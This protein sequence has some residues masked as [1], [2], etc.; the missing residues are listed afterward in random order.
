MKVKLRGV[1][2][3]IP[4]ALLVAVAACDPPHWRYLVTLAPPVALTSLRDGNAIALGDTTQSSPSPAAAVGKIGSASAVDL[5]SFDQ[6]TWSFAQRLEPRQ[7]A[8]GLFATSVALSG[9]TLAIGAYHDDP[10]KINNGYVDIY[11]RGN[12]NW[13]YQQTVTVS[14]FTPPPNNTGSTEF[15][16]ARSIDLDGDDLV[17]GAGRFAG[18]YGRAFVFHRTAGVFVQVAELKE[19]DADQRFDAN[20][21]DTVRIKGNTIIATR[22]D[23]GASTP[24][25]KAGKVYVYVSAG[26]TWAIQQV[27][28]SPTANGSY[29]GFGN[30]ASLWGDKLA[31]RGPNTAYV[32]ARSSGA[33]NLAW[34]TAVGPADRD[35]IDIIDDYIA[36]GEPS[37]TANGALNAGQVRVFIANGSGY[38]LQALRNEPS[39]GTGHAFGARVAI[40]GIQLLVGAPGVF[41]GQPTYSATLDYIDGPY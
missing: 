29:D 12:A 3:W 2:F 22:P 5:F 21:G 30:A 23:T 26:G 33:W 14:S 11:V 41:T 16:F 27:L 6:G 20:F 36:I 17:V 37:A 10:Q 13:A 31:V 19:A 34:S 39:P 35:S 4:T 7:G 25:P 24:P 32:F 18:G 8:L 15:G 28:Q 38:A 40:R 9:N 1:S